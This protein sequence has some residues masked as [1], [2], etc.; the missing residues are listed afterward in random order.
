M[1]TERREP[2]IEILVTICGYPGANMLTRSTTEMEIASL[3]IK[4][5]CTKLGE[6]TICDNM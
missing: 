6:T 4:T 1:G 3:A 2:T 5:T